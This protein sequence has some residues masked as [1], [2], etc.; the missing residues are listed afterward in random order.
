MMLLKYKKYFKNF[1]VKSGAN[2]STK[3]QGRNS[4]EFERINTKINKAES[5]LKTILKTFKV[6]NQIKRHH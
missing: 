4:K 1:K 6:K 3:M 5:D 2:P